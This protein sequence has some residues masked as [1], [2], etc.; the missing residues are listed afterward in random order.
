MS[1]FWKVAFLCILSNCQKNHIKLYRLTCP[2]FWRL[3]IPFPAGQGPLPGEH[4]SSSMP[5]FP[6]IT[7]FFNNSAP[8]F[9]PLFTRSKWRIP[10]FSFPVFPFCFPCFVRNGFFNFPSLSALCHPF[11]YTFHT[12][13]YNCECKFRKIFSEKTSK[14]PPFFWNYPFCTKRLPPSSCNLLILLPTFTCCYCLSDRFLA[15]EQPGHLSF[16]FCKSVIIFY[17]AWGFGFILRG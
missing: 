13:Q 16:Y 15:A 3:S 9:Y 7:P 17:K 11:I 14:L 6:F 10:H 5:F 8:L 2:P 4:P 12:K 1:K